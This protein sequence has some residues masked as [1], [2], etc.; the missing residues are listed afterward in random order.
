MIM[1]ERKERVA[2]LDRQIDR[3][4]REKADLYEEADYLETLIR[5][6]ER[7]ADRLEGME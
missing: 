4:N 5:E 1:N 3:L 6:Y 2:Y 7:E